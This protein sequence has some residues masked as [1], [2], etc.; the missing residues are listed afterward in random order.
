MRKSIFAGMMIAI[1]GMAYLSVGGIEGAVLFSFGLLAI[2]LYQANLFTGKIGFLSFNKYP[3]LFYNILCGNLIGVSLVSI[4]LQLAGYNVNEQVSMIINSRI[5][6]SYTSCLIKAIFCGVLMTVSIYGYLKNT[7]L[8][9]LWAV[10][11]FILSGYYH[12]IAEW[13]YFAMNGYNNF[14]EYF[15]KWI[16]IVCGNVIGCNIP[17]FFNE[18]KMK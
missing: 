11:V 16:I 8:P 4:L 12:S 14:V 6:N 13:F 18:G 7:M 17:R 2:T 1:A 10:P 9:L 3:Y 15:P 5:E